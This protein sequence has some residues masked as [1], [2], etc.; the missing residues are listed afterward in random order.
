[1]EHTPRGLSQ[2]SRNLWAG[3]LGQAASASNAMVSPE[4]D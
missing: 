1:M 2:H 3:S 4:S